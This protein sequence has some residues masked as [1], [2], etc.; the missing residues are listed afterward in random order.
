MLRLLEQLQWA[1]SEATYAAH[2]I[3]LLEVRVLL[4]EL[5]RQRIS[6]Q[7][8]PLTLEDKVTAP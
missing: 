7:P 8:S 2:P 5:M 3:R 4:A 6:A 1:K